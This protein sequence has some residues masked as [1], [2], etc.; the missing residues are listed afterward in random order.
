MEV[1]TTVGVII[2]VKINV[3]DHN[4]K[5]QFDIVVSLLQQNP[6]TRILITVDFTRLKY[7]VLRAPIINENHVECQVYQEWVHHQGAEAP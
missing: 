2:I 1:K 5:V 3:V 4:S 7:L 6:F